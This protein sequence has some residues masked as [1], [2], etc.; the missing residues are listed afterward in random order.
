VVV[1]YKK[2][3][4]KAE[5]VPLP[6]IYIICMYIIYN[7]CKYIHNIYMYVYILYIYMYHTYMHIYI[8]IYI[9][10][11]LC[12]CLCLCPCPCSCIRKCMYMAGAQGGAVPKQETNCV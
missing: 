7:I 9:Y 6:Y 12:L 2:R 8:Y 4:E 3:K 10:L 5:S 1:P 11:Y